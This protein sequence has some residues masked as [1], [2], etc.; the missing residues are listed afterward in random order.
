MSR[1]LNYNYSIDTFRVIAAFAVITLHTG[2]FYDLA[3]ENTFYSNFPRLIGIYG[4]FAVP[5]FFAVAGYFFGK[6]SREQNSVSFALKKYCKRLIKYFFFW[7]TVYFF[8]PGFRASSS[9]ENISRFY[10][11]IFDLQKLYQHVLDMFSSPL[12][13]LLCGTSPHLWFITALIFSVCLTAFLVS[14]KREGLLL[15]ISVG[16]FILAMLRCSYFAATGNSIFLNFFNVPHFFAPLFFVI[17]Y[18]LSG[19]IVKKNGLHYGMIAAGIILQL[20][21]TWLSSAKGYYNIGSVLVILGLLQLVLSRPDIGKNSV[22]P[23]IGRLAP[24]V[25]GIHPIICYLIFYFKPPVHYAVWQVLYPFEVLILSL[26]VIAV[27]ARF[28]PFRPFL[29]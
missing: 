7:T 14:I 11:K 17:G 22:L 28:K 8:V 25:Y 2:P 29:M 4:N 24:G 27:L 21:E 6:I 26:A 23:K 5:F 12:Y 9:M 15:I 18:F 20:V 1:E 13:L 10:N 19:R 16:M 3:N